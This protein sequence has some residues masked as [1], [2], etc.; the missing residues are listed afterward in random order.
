M[1][2]TDPRTHEAARRLSRRKLLKTAG[3]VGAAGIAGWTTL[4]GRSAASPTTAWAA[5]APKAGGRFSVGLLVA[6]NHLDPHRV[7]NQPGRWV[8]QMIYSNLVEWDADMKIKGDLAESWELRDERTHVFHLRRNAKFHNNRAVAAEDVKYSLER[9]MDPATHSL[10]ATT[11]DVVDRIDTPDKYTVIIRLKKPFSPLLAKLADP[12]V[13]IVSREFVEQN[14]GDLRSAA[15]GSGPFKLAEYVQGD[16]ARL[17]K[18][19][20]YYMPGVPRVDEI[21][22]RA[23]PDESARH[24]ALRAGDINVDTFVLTSYVDELRKARGVRVVGGDSG[25][26][27]YLMLNMRADKNFPAGRNLKFRQAMAWTV[28]RAAIVQTALFGQGYPLLGPI[29]P[30][31]WAALKTPVVK[32]DPGRAKQLMAESGLRN[33]TMSVTGASERKSTIDTMVLIKEQVAPLQITINVQ[34]E[35][36]SIFYNQ[37]ANADFQGLVEGFGGNVD[38]DDFLYERFR[39]NGKTNFMGYSNQEV[40]RLLEQ[41]RTVMGESERRDIYTRAQQII[42]TDAPQIMLFSMRQYEG[43]RDR[44]QDF[45]H[46]P[47]MNLIALKYAWLI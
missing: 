32:V 45:F 38:P 18:N 9:I 11:F 16:H 15:M 44:V 25:N 29:P 2:K 46:Q 41:G 12:P 24:N 17:V 5:T 42:V 31:H 40:D 8:D 37:M 13:A 20:D 39:S 23:M 33:V 4:R 43:L 6:P 3:A 1:H 35:E 19:G 28:D 47:T 36:S 22:F 14:K 7:P 21:L 26:F 34:P 27:Y 30:Y 10:Y